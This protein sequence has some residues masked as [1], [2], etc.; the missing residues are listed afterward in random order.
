MNGSAVITSAEDSSVACAD[1]NQK[2]VPS[3]PF[4][5][6]FFCEDSG[7]CLRCG[8]QKCKAFMTKN[9]LVGCINCG[10]VRRETVL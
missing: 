5:A 1:T 8:S 6:G 3:M 2:S 10:H 7:Q 4:D 9:N